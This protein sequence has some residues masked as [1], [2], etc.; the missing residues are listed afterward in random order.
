M[1]FD[2]D[3]IKAISHRDGPALVIAGPGSGKT[4]VLTNRIKNLIKIYH[5]RPENI[6]VITFS[7]AAAVSMQERFDSICE[8]TF[9]PV[10]FG[11]FHSVFFNIL[12]NFYRY[13]TSHII[14]LKEKRKLLKVALQKSINMQYPENELLDEL[15]KDIG[16]YK[17]CAEKEYRTDTSLDFDNFNKIYLAYCELQRAMDK[18][19]FEDMML[20]VKD[21]FYKRADVLQYYQERYKYILIDE[22]QDINNIQY[23]IVRMIAG[24]TSNLWVCGDD[25][26]A[27]Y[28][29]RAA[30]PR[31]ML[32]FPKDYPN[33]AIYKLTHNYRSSEEIIESAGKVILENKTRFNKDITGTGRRAG[34]VHLTSCNDKEGENAFLIQEIEKLRKTVK[35]SDIALLLRTNKEA[36]MYAELLRSAGMEVSMTEKVYNPYASGYYRDISHYLHLVDGSELSRQ[37]LLPVLNKPVRYLRRDMFDKENLN[38]DRIIDSQKDNR[39]IANK[40]KTLKFQLTKMADMDL[41][42]R[43]NY[44]RKYIGYDE[45]VKT[46]NWNRVAYENYVEIIEWIQNGARR[47]NTIEEM[48]E[49]AADYEESLRSELEN[50]HKEKDAGIQ[51]MTFHASKGLEF[52]TVII[53]HVNEGSI[54]NKKSTGD[55]IEE[56]RRMFYVAM[57]RA[58]RR[59]ILTYTQGKGDRKHMPSRFIYPL[60]H[61][62]IV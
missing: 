17:N 3:Q 48:D 5:V 49:Y 21:L 27:I 57:T 34:E 10:T 56:E 40:L 62:I 4:A 55:S 46:S 25:D 16:Y 38:L 32:D 44:I 52:D 51:I 15:I 24:E 45:Y 12:H 2:P 7:K 11:T 53:P 37:H 13:N 6:L 18:I 8:D 22:Y 31:I 9:Y 1:K 41:Y 36:S 30:N 23:E 33:A 59:L 19:D 50:R 35:D 42:A 43:I 26:Q 47:F 29:F 61:R 20:L 39:A 60:L 14:S 58:K 54:P 28:S